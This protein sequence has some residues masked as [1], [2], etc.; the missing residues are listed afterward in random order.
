MRLHRRL[1][2]A[3]AACMLACASAQAGSITVYS[4]LE[5]DEISVYLAAARQAMPDL[6]VHVLRLSTGD[7][8]ARLI[9]ES[10]APRNDV[11][12]GEALTD[13]LDPRIEAGLAPVTST[14]IAA[15]PA[16]Y[17]A[18]DNKWFAPTGYVAAMCVNT[19][20]L[21]A[22]HLPMPAS[23]ADLT[24]PIYKGQ[25]VMPD[26]QSSGTGYMM[27]AAILQ[28][29]GPGKGWATLKALSGN[30]AQFTKSGSNPCKLARTGEFPIGVSFAFVAM[31]AIRQGFPIKMVIPA[32]NVGYEL[33]ASGLM[34]TSTHQADA[35]RFLD[36]TAS[37]QAVALYRQYKDLVA[38]PTAGPTPEQIQAGLPADIERR[39]YPL[40]F[41]LSA[42][43]RA[44]VIGK[45][46]SDI[47]H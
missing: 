37:P 41:P 20:A 6:Q 24:K 46:N 13:M 9:A 30:V 15:L 12:W 25:V 8:A 36:W 23:W 45:W 40:D 31:Q 14:S 19:E 5:N 32:D 28:G 26:P 18:S 34:K 4:A 22:Q 1:A 16:R 38:A 35:K 47:A 42:R 27:I 33:E 2:A 29:M 11:I 43:S 39:L 10:A 3:L 44:A 21:A 17:R 7:L